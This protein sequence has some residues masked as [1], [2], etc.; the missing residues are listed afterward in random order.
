MKFL[1]FLFHLIWKSLWYGFAAIVVLAAVLFSI[2]RMLL[3][4]LGDYSVTVEDYFSQFVNQP[5]RIQSLDAEW[6]GW[7]PSLV[8]NN[9]W[10]LDSQGKNTIVRVAK[11]HLGLGLWKTI[12]TGQLGFTSADLQGVDLSITRMP[13]GQITL[14]GFEILTAT[15]SPVVD[16]TFLEWLL[17]QGH[18]GIQFR[19][20]LY[21]DRIAGGRKHLFSNVTLSLMNQ[22]DHHLMEGWIDIPK[23]PDQKMNIFVDAYGDLLQSDQWSGRLYVSGNEIN[24]INLI[25][26]LTPVAQKFTVGTSDFEIWST[27]HKAK[28]QK[29]QG[30]FAFQ[31]VAIKNRPD[32]ATQDSGAQGSIVQYQ[33]LAGRFVWEQQSGGWQLQADQ[34]F[35]KNQNRQWPDSQIRVEYLAAEDKNSKA[36]NYFQVNATGNFLRTQ[37]LTPL[38]GLFEVQETEVV[39]RLYG[40]KAGLDIHDYYMRY[41]AAAQ[42]S[43]EFS[44][45]IKDFHTVAH[46]NIPGLKNVS[47]RIRMDE[48]SGYFLLNSKNTIID[49]PQ[50]FRHDIVLNELQGELGWQV[51]NS[52]FSLTGRNVHLREA[53]FTLEALL[54]IEIPLEHNLLSSNT[55]TSKKAS[56]KSALKSKQGPYINLI[57]EFANGDGRKA[58]RKMPVKIMGPQLVKW[59]DRAIVDG[60]VPSGNLVFHGDVSDFPFRKG[61]GVFKIKFDVERGIL[62][63]AQDWPPL[64]DVDA[65]VEFDGPSLTI[66]SNKGQ[67]LQSKISNTVVTVADLNSKPLTISIKGDVNGTTQDK[68]DYILLSPPLRRKFGRFFEDVEVSGDS[69][70]QLDVDLYVKK[71]DVSADVNGSLHLVENKIRYL[72]FGEPLTE[73]KGKINIVPQGIKAK[74]LNMKFYGQPTSVDIKTIANNQSNESE[75]IQVS[76]KGNFDSHDL[77]KRYLPV[78]SDL[79]SGHSDWTVVSYIPVDNTPGTESSVIEPIRFTAESNLKGVEVRLP[80]PFKKYSG[81]QLPTTIAGSLYVDSNYLF[82]VNY[83]NR[84]TGIMENSVKGEDVWRGEFRF[85]KGE[86][87]LPQQEGFRFVGHVQELSADVWRSLISQVSDGSLAIN[88]QDH[89]EKILDWSKLFH[90][91]DLT[92]DHFQLFGQEAK[93]MVLNMVGEKQSMLLNVNS[94]EL[95]GE[96]RI[97]HDLK[98]YPLELNLDRWELTSA[99]EGGHADIDPREIPAIKAFAKSVSYKDRRFG[100]VKLEA[101]K[102]VEGLRLE[103]LVMKPRSTTILANGKWTIVGG[104][105]KSDFELHL[106]SQNLG[107]TMDDLDYVGSI[108]EG[109]GDID[110]NVSWPG[111]LTDVDLE[112]LQGN[113]SINFK[114]GKLLAIDSGAGR[115]FG[116]FSL[117]TLPKRLILDFSDLYEKGIVFNEIAGNFSIEDGD[118]YTN[119][120]YL[121][122]PAAK[123]QAAGRIGLASQDYDQL[124]TFTPRTADIVSMIGLLVSTPWGFVI[125]QI[126][127]ENI[128]KAMSFQ[129]TL[130]GSWDNPQLEPVIKPEPVDVFSE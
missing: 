110:I 23:Q 112:H 11:A 63:Y 125:P 50:L 6:R 87:E 70:L 85:G 3:P 68:A 98:R 97:P 46:K 88:E 101:T 111:A 21:E 89:G 36:K 28:L 108:S 48:K 30:K 8:L 64:Q 31:D 105:Q 18:I 72:W 9:V 92:I 2:T 41:S 78:L 81:Q 43:F 106:D 12:K 59:L 39:K 16:N 120:F 96:I 107:E 82:R 13:D 60:R 104:E 52:T 124:L 29:M 127:R 84:F 109:E 76:A 40:A 80:T 4:T 69:R 7:G 27:W 10:L 32:S 19:N 14:T 93:N 79:V 77:S 116:L 126:F 58:T 91:A 56:K 17:Q 83:G 42:P 22:G 117:Q 86:V 66:T 95:K 62:D 38:L 75:F 94:D 25:S 44:A 5:I 115:I 61:E 51:D 20:L 15:E 1:F 129:Y 49:M 102:L 100:S 67:V 71:Q 73:V 121:D 99:A 130:T 54:D 26:S 33:K 37:D 103:Q 122:G 74:G 123:A 90:S 47:G 128:N 34:V 24:I 65:T 118:A 114:K 55:N 57:A 45:D 35:I 53:E 119:N 113:V